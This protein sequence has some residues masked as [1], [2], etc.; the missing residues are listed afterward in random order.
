M[1][2]FFAGF[3]A[4]VGVHV[5]IVDAERSASR[6]LSPYIYTINVRHGNFSWTVHRRY[7]HFFKLN[8]AIFV[9]R[10][11]PHFR[12][13]SAED[14]ADKVSSRGSFPLTFLIDFCAKLHFVWE[15]MRKETKV[16]KYV[17]CGGRELLTHDT[18]QWPIIFSQCQAWHYLSL[19]RYL[20]LSDPPLLIFLIEKLF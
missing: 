1:Q 20:V 16:A 15:L 4:G 6:G 12:K 2:L 17:W 11:K 18:R 14:F 3:L 10:N 7:H 5:A 13:R 8:T 19:F 9:S